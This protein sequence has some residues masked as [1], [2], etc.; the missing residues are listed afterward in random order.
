MFD[1]IPYRIGLLV[2][3]ALAMTVGAYHRLRARSEERISHKEEGYAFAIVLRL[4]GLV[5]WLNTF[6]Y[7]I[8]PSAV[9]WAKFPLPGW[10]RWIG[11]VSG[12]FGALLM[13]WT[14]SSLGKNLTDTVV[15]RKNATLI[16]HG[17]YRWVRHPFY[18]TA[19][20]LMGSVTVLTANWMIGLSSALILALLAIRT[21]KEEQKLVERF[22]Q[23]YLDYWQRT[24]RFI[25]RLRHN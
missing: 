11:A 7:L 10:A 19:A 21:P 20:V 6:A 1:E 12:V 24:G 22:G 16:T 14:L 25:P 9:T 2:V 8:Y 23:Q 18:V 4:I 15:V 13:Y 17:P 3:F 5:L